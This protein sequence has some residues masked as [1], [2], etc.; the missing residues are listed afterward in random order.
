MQPH[1]FAQKWRTRAYEVTEEQA[2]QEHYQDVAS[3]VGGFAPGQAGAPEGLTY[4]AGVKKVGTTDFGKADVFQPGHFI[5]EAKRAAKTD[6]ARAKTLGGAL[7]QATLY[8]RDLGN[9]P[10]IVTTDFVELNVHTNFTGTAPKTFRMTLED[11]EHDRKLDGTELSALQVLRAVFHDPGVLDPR[12][13]RERITTEATGRV[14]E[15]ARALVK[16]GYPKEQVAHFLM[17]VVFAMFSEDVALLDKGLLTKLLER[18]KKYPEKSQGYFAELFGAMSTGGEFWGNDIRYFNGG[19]FDNHDGLPITAEDA[20]ALLSAAKLDWAEVEP[21]IFGRLFESSLEKEVRGQRGAHF[22]AVPEIERIVEPVVMLDLF[23]QWEEVRARAQ[24]VVDQAE[25][26]AQAEESKG[27]TRVA[28]NTRDKARKQ[29]IGI[30]HEFQKHLGSIKVLDAA[31]GSGNFLYVTLKRLLDL[32]HEVRLTAFQYGVGDFDI[33]PLVHPRKMLGIE[34][35][36]F[37][38]ELAAVTLWIGYFQWNRAHGGQW[39]T[40]V[41]ERLDNIQHHDALL[42]DDGS[43]FQWPEATYIVGNPPFLGEK[44]QGPRLGLPY[45]EQLRST[46]AGRVP[47]TSDLVCYWFEKARAAIEQGKTR[48]AG[49]I[50]TNS[51]NMPGNRAVLERIN[52]T[53]A[54]FRAWPNLPWLQDGA[55]V[56][57]AAISFD[58]GRE[59]QRAIGEL[60]HEGKE[61][62]ESIL[63]PVAAINPNLS[64]GTNVTEAKKLPENAGL[65][66]QGVKLAGDFDITE[67][68]AREWMKL[69]NLGNAENS[70]VLRPL[71]NGDDLTSKRGDT[72]VIDFA[73]MTEAKASEYLVP[74]AHVVEKVKPVREK[75]RDKARRTNWWQLARPYTAMREALAPLPRYLATSIVAKHRTFLWCDAK[76]LPSGRLVVVASDQDWMYGVLNSQIHVVWAAANSS[77]HGK[78]NDL[79]YTSTTCFEPF[80]FPQWTPGTQEAVAE[81]ARFVEK[82]R[83]G[84]KD[85]GMTITEM[86][87]ALAEVTGTDSP[88]YTLKLAHDRLDGAVAAAYGW[89][90]RLEE[91]EV[92]ARLLALNLQ[93][94]DKL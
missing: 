55:A 43:E 11:I 4:Q 39:P 77:T 10:L 69:P 54:M 36:G 1:E 53:G 16:A 8:A 41:L 89:E 70:D 84:L 28:D 65:C 62:E 91:G 24:S 75:N 63:T 81:A 52:E 78:G 87:N 22:T 94:S 42:N 76:D 48:R 46:Y 93:R 20:D 21:A 37:A 33:P 32:E 18:A 34:V 27:H 74:F 12:L 61:N 57:V 82:V 3:L 79:T 44:K 51:I 72:W 2:Y 68:V 19:L 40:P 7:Q 85:Q 66:F 13:V 56:R 64:V 5:W 86:Y 25:V 23:R 80:P 88:A 9:P 29:A 30:L 15:V 67:A 90:W 38:A 73:S 35:E 49:L 17:R 14:G 26:K 31:C 92:L 59:Q 6:A 45:V 83:A 50:T 60:L 71:L 58:D 47:K